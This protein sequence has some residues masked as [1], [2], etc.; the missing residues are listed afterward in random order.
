MAFVFLLGPTVYI[1]DTIPA[2]VGGH[3][4]N[5]LPMASRTGTF[6]DQ[7][8][9]GTWTIF[10]WAWWLSWAPFVGTF[11]ARISHG[12]DRQGIQHGSSCCGVC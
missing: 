1:L 8:W 2:S 6:S 11:I 3:L 9:P 10:Y 4:Q 12:A 5:L 7:S